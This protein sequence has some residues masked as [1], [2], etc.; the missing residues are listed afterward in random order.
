MVGGASLL[1][2]SLG[3]GVLGASLGD[4]QGAARVQLRADEEIRQLKG[5]ISL[6]EELEKI[7]IDAI[8]GA[9][10]AVA[11]KGLGTV[12]D[13]VRLLRDAVD[14]A[15]AAVVAVEE[16]LPA[17]R[18]GAA[19]AD[20][21]VAQVKRQLAAIQDA[22][23][24]ATG[25]LRPAADAV[26]GLLSELVSRIPFGVGDKILEAN[27]RTSELVAALPG[28]MD[29]MGRQL[30]APLSADW[31]SEEEGKGLKGLLLDP[32]RGNLLKPLRGFLDDVVTFLAG[33]E[34]SLITPG[35]AVLGDR[36][37]VRQRISQYKASLAVAW[38]GSLE[39]GG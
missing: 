21:F 17:L 34:G 10:I 5:L 35:K 28:A 25:Q 36:E 29:A 38:T 37:R 24:A 22:V 39:A 27:R 4:A 1:A 16:A 20:A 19:L 26:G 9:G 11:E 18:S 30:L 33:L 6:Y 13:G 12:K 2:G 31:L 7:G 23:L 14:L 15:D 3:G 8:V 32:L